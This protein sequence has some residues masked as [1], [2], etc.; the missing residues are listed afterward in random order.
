MLSQIVTDRL[1]L[2]P[3]VFNLQE[4]ET[5]RWPVRESLKSML[6]MSWNIE[7]TKEGEAMF[8]QRESEKQRKISDSQVRQLMYHLLI[9]IILVITVLERRFAFLKAVF[10]VVVKQLQRLLWCFYTVCSRG[11]L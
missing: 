7:R 5:Y 9:V 10:V 6:A 8:Q 1:T 11:N 2:T 3:C 4:R